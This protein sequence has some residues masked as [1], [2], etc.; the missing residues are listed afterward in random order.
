MKGTMIFEFTMSSMRILAAVLLLSFVVGSGCATGQRRVALQERLGSLVGQPID[1]A[2]KLW[3]AA[4]ATQQMTDGTTV[5]T[6]RL[7]WTSSSV[8]YGVPGG[9]VVPHQHLCRITLQT[10]STSTIRSYHYEDC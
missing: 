3:G 5:Y 2:V 10:D 6:W 8:N 9:A 4:D 7:P 1:E